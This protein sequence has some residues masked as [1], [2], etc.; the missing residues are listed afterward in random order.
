M[1]T[2]PEPPP[3]PMYMVEMKATV[4]H[5]DGSYSWIGIGGPYEKDEADQ[6]LQWVKDKHPERTYRLKR[7]EESK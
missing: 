4:P 7:T 2:P 6:K 1:T 5:F 3:I